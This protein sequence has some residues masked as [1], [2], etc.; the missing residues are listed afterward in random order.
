MKITTIGLEVAKHVLQIYGVDE[1]GTVAVK[2]QLKRSQV[3]EYFANL[4]LPASL[5]FLPAQKTT[6]K[7]F[8]VYGAAMYG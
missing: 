3:A 6:L 2:K 4:H 7:S 5:H 1:Q 8:C